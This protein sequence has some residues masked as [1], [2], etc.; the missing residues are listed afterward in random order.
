MPISKV[1]G[2][3]KASYAGRT[4]TFKTKAAAEKWSSKYTK[5]KKEVAGSRKKSR[6]TRR[7]GKRKSMFDQYV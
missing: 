3:W 5:K 6:R 7:P 1:E 4:A 2:G